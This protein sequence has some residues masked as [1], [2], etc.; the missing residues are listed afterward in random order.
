M[1]LNNGELWGKWGTSLLPSLLGPR[2]PRVVAP[3]RVLSM[4][5]IELF[6]I[7]TVYLCENEFFETELFLHLT[8]E[9]ELLEI[10]L[11]D[12]LTVCKQ[13]TDV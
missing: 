12:L 13:I 4:G 8:Y 9:T 3:Y 1:T 2:S 7:L 11:F 10:E 6:D 5:Q